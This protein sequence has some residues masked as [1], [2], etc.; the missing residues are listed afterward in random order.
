MDSYE[1]AADIETLTLKI[2]DLIANEETGVAVSALMAVLMRMRT[3]NG[4]NRSKAALALAQAFINL[5]M[6]EH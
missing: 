5:A 1:L 3:R 4:D 6:D 2:E